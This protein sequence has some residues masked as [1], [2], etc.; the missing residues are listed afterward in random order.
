MLWLTFATNV[1]ARVFDKEAVVLGTNVPSLQ[2]WKVHIT[3][4][5]FSS[6]NDQNCVISERIMPVFMTWTLSNCVAVLWQDPF[7]KGGLK[8]VCE[9]TSLYSYHRSVKRMFLPELFHKNQYPS[10][11]LLPKLICDS[12]LEAS[13]LIPFLTLSAFQTAYPSTS[14]TLWV[15]HSEESVS[16]TCLCPPPAMEDISV[17]RHFR[18]TSL[19]AP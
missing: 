17:R 15:P 6:P 11:G 2:S 18:S 4:S 5:P 14:D 13:V 10:C 9:A 1:L 3:F 16:L 7:L 12:S 19:V 8:Q